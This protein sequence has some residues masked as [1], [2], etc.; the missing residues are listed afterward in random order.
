M[1]S[2]IQVRGIDNKPKASWEYVV[3]DF[4]IPGSIASEKVL[5]N[6]RRELHVVDK[7]EPN[8]LIGMDIIGPERVNIYPAN[9]IAKVGSC[10]NVSIPLGV[11]D[12]DL[13]KVLQPVLSAF[14]AAIPPFSVA[15]VAIKTAKLPSDRD[16]IFLSGTQ[17]FTSEDLYTSE[18][19]NAY[20]CDSMTD[21]V[22][23]RN[24]AATCLKIPMG[25]SLGTMTECD[26]ED[27]LFMDSGATS[28]KESRHSPNCQNAHAPNYER[29]CDMTAARQIV[30]ERLSCT[31]ANDSEH[32]PSRSNKTME[33]KLSNGIT[34]Y[35]D[36]NT[37]E[38]FQNL[39]NQFSRLW[40]DWGRT[41]QLSTDEMLRVP[42]L[43]NWEEKTKLSTKVYPLSEKDREIVDHEFDKLQNQGR[44]SWTTQPTPFA[45]PVF[46]VWR[47]VNSDGNTQRKRRVVVDIRGLT[48]IT[49]ADSYPLPLQTDIT[50]A[51]R[52]AAFISTVD[53]ASFF[54]Q[55]EVHPDDRHKLTVV[56]HRGQ[57]SFNVAVMGYKNSPPYVQRQMD[58]MLR[59]HQLYAKGYVDD[60]VVFSKTLD[61]HI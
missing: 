4:Y 52:G 48:K 59:P 47:T 30:D 31:P 58:R 6:F 54:Y 13:R 24:T 10:R 14:P 41:V 42:L 22:L 26:V 9:R 44:M 57:E 34:I 5:A 23:V 2:P 11:S 3:A 38:H 28:T 33:T 46:V 12:R 29:G 25:S 18:R 45:F 60:I 32:S 56:S 17:G 55:W 1:H 61:D 8:I 27:I 35:G 16:F 51:V 21:F 49:V 20:L 40:E 7:L 53:C 50:S 37:V 36:P 39:V 19:M 43:P 15:N